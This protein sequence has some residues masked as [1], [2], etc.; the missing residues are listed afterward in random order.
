MNAEDFAPKTEIEKKLVDA[1]E[2][3][4][5]SEDFMQELL[6]ATLFLPV[7]DDSVSGI[8]LS[9]KTRPISIE[10]EDGTQIMVVFTSPDR[11]GEFLEQAPGQ[12]GGILE[13]FRWIVEH[14]GTG[15]G[16][17]INPGWDFGLD[18]EPEMVA[19]LSP[20]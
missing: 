10:L 5:S 6:D 19:Q 4:L 7:Y 12:S 18:I 2:G 14:A 11:A 1:Q 3:R 13:S 15:V 16:I 20:Q 9:D 8:P 17:S